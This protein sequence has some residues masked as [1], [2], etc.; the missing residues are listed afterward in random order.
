MASFKK[1]ISFILSVGL[2]LLVNLNALHYLVIE[3]NAFY[4]SEISTISNDQKIH[5][6]DDFILHNIFFLGQLFT[7]KI[8]NPDV[9]VCY[10]PQ[11]IH[12]VYYS[13]YKENNLGR[14]PP[15]LI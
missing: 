7:L 14:D 1:H 11:H 10:L 4:S 13:N 8:N 3:H 5:N 9:K 2:L 6:C 15:C 12:L